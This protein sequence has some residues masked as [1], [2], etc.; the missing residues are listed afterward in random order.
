MKNQ[1]GFTLIEVMIVV[2]IVA[3]LA[4]IAVPSYQDSIRKTRRADAKEALTRIA[5][6][7]ERFFFT[8]N[9]YGTA[10]DL[11]ISAASQEGHYIID[12]TA[13]VASAACGPVD[14]TRCFKVTATT[15]GAQASDTECQIF[16]IN[17]IGQK[18]AN[19]VGGADNTDVCW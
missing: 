12:L 1:K 18:T 2:V 17:H 13:P 14:A 8:N 19:K 11:G 9:R 5:A 4:A 16:S 10:D 6:L 7:Q 3:I 15:Q